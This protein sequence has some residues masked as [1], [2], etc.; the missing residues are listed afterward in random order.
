MAAVDPVGTIRNIANQDQS[1]TIPGNPR[2]FWIW[3]KDGGFDLTHPSSPGSDPVTPSLKLKCA[4]TPVLIDPA[5]TALLIIDFQNCNVSRALGSKTK[6]YFDAEENILTQA[7][8]TA[9]RAGIQIIWLTT[10]YSEQDLKEMDPSP[11]RIFGWNP[12]VQ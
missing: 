4:L 7:I 1:T 6:A 12:N 2:N 10:D 11:L 9:R 8:P 5:K 3:S